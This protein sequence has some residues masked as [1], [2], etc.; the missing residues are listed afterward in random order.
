MITERMEFIN[1]SRK[2]AWQCR[3]QLIGS[4]FYNLNCVIFNENVINNILIVTTIKPHILIILIVRKGSNDL[5]Y[6]V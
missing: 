3:F 2:C 1:A 5:E 6:L 4:C